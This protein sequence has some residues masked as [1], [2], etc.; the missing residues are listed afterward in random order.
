MV[1]FLWALHVM[2]T[3][4]SSS[5]CAMRLMKQLPNQGRLQQLINRLAKSRRIFLD[6]SE[7]GC[8]HHWQ[9]LCSCA[10]QLTS[11]KFVLNLLIKQSLHELESN[12]V[13]LI[14]I[15]FGANKFDA[16]LAQFTLV[17][18]DF[19]LVGC[20]TL[21]VKDRDVTSEQV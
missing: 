5:E 4:V 12:Q 15:F 13:P 1:V 8:G 16:F 19:E 14:N 18:E 20:T 9:L 3:K 11:C 2:R 21:L 6:S 17:L 10:S 7:R